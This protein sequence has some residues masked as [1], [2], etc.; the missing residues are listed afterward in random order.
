MSE[1]APARARYVTIDG[2]PLHAR[3]TIRWDFV[4]PSKDRFQQAQPDWTAQ[5]M[6]GAASEHEWITLP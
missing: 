1:N 5:R 3:R 2:E 6:G 4:A